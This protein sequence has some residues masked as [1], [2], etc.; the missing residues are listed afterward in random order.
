MFIGTLQLVVLPEAGLKPTFGLIR[1]L[2]APLGRRL[3][4]RREKIPNHWLF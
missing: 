3:G 2:V 1:R 4:C